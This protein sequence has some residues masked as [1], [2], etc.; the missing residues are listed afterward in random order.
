MPHVDV[1]GE[2]IFYAHHRLPDPKAPHLILVHGAGG[3]P[4]ELDR[5][6]SE[7]LA[8]SEFRDG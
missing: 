5:G 2:R 1:D 6:P 3:L 4:R 7:F 8:E